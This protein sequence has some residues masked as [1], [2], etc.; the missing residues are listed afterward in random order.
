MWYPF[1]VQQEFLAE[2]K[3]AAFLLAESAPLVVPLKPSQVQSVPRWKMLVQAAVALLVLLSQ[4]TFPLLMFP[5]HAQSDLS[6]IDKHS[7][8]FHKFAK[9]DAGTV[10]QMHQRSVYA[11][12]FLA[13]C[14]LPE[15]WASP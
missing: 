10:A 14:R 6:A 2:K 12:A 5:I 9:L 4:Q 15:E 11:L 8:V 3:Q 1:L 7:A 13:A